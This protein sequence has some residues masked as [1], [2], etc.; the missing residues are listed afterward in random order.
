MAS[1]VDD[2][3]FDFGRLL[4]E[5]RE[6]KNISQVVLAERANVSR[7]II[8]AYESMSGRRH[9]PTLTMMNRVACALGVSVPQLLLGPRVKLDSTERGE[10]QAGHELIAVPVYRKLQKSMS[11]LKE[12]TEVG[13][14]T[15]SSLAQVGLNEGN[16][17]A[18][19]TG[20]DHLE[21]MWPTIQSGDI[22][23]FDMSRTKPRS[24]EVV[25][26]FYKGKPHIRRYVVRNRA[27]VLV[28]DNPT[29]PDIEVTNTE[30]CIFAG[31]VV[32]TVHRFAV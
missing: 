4:K 12:T 8:Q 6:A 24:Q 1:Q 19:F 23:F 5:W 32:A 25:G 28:A 22:I 29:F 15:R 9:S 10:G 31:V 21:E 14:M 16:C 7:Q 27:V 20:D 30:D 17:A 18:Y 13:W 11:E 26:C 2:N 3:G